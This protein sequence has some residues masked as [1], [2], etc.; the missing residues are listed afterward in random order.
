MGEDRTDRHTALNESINYLGQ[1]VFKIQ[2]LYDEIVGAIEP[3]TAESEKAETGLTLS[4][5]LE[6]APEEIRAHADI[7]SKLVGDIHSRIF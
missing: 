3:L 7:I 6:N 5:T 2:K 1:S 4:S